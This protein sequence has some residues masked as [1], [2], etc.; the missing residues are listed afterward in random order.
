MSGKIVTIGVNRTERF[1]DILQST[2]VSLFADSPSRLVPYM[3]HRG[4]TEE[5]VECVS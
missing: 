1:I 5:E 3:N 2:E 4:F